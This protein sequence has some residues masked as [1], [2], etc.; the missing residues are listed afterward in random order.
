MASHG[1][2]E[3]GEQASR[4]GPQRSVLPNELNLL[5]RAVYV[6]GTVL[7]L[8]ARTAGFALGS[9]QSIWEASE[10]AF[11]AGLDES[12]EDARIIEEV[13]RDQT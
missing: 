5:G 8:A 12:V 3:S 7:G 1:R 13:D 4:R 10:R 2:D 9:A 11:H 6:A